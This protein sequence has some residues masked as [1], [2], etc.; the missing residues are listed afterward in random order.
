MMYTLFWLYEQK[1]TTQTF[2]NVKV[3]TNLSP[4]SSLVQ[5]IGLIRGGEYFL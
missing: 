1:F 2:F 3:K 5:V 4:K